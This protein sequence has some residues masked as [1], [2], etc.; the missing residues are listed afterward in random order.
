MRHAGVDVQLRGHARV[1]QDALVDQRVVAQR[2][3]AAHLEIRPG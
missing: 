1:A 3:E 2:V